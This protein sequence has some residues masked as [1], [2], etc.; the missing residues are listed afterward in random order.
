L[1]AQ[2]Y[3]LA[4]VFFGFYCVLLGYLIFRSTFFPIFLG[5]LVALS[6]LALLTNSFTIFLSP[7]AGTVV[8][9][10]MDALDGIGEISLALWLLLVGVN[11]SKWHAAAKTG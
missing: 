11:I 10:F 9:P 1:H 7:G 6:G 3:L 8:A 5:I 4:L 2:A